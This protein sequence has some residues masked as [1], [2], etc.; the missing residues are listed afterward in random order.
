MFQEHPVL[1][2]YIVTMNSTTHII[3]L[4]TGRVFNNKFLLLRNFL[5]HVWICIAIFSLAANTINIIVFAKIGLKDNATITLF[6]L[7]A[8]DLLNLIINTPIIVGRYMQKNEPQHLWQFDF[9]ILILGPFWYAYVF[10]DYSSF[11]SVFL[12]NAMQ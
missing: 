9:F 1:V 11:T 8:S 10:Y 3:T 6:F 7:S 4:E 2:I 5:Y 12:A